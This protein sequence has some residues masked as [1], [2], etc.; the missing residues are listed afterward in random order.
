MK[1]FNNNDIK[2]STDAKC[3]E[4]GEQ[5]Y[6]QQKINAL[7]ITKRAIDDIKLTASIADE[8]G[9]YQQ[10]ISLA[11]TIDEAYEI[12]SGC[13]CHAGGNCKHIVA[14]LLAYKNHESSTKLAD[15]EKQWLKQV[16]TVEL[17]SA[18]PEK[19]KFIAYLLKKAPSLNTV[20]VHFRLTHLLQSA[21][22]ANGRVIQLHHFNNRLMLPEYATATDMDIAKAL[23]DISGDAW[24]GIPLKGEA[25]Y[26]ALQK[27][28]STEHVYWVE[29]AHMPLRA[30]E[31]RVAELK[32]QN[33]GRDMRRLS[34]QILPD[35][36]VIQTSPAWYLDSKT[37]DVGPMQGASFTPHQWQVL[38][39]LPDIPLSDVAKYGA[40]ISAVLPG[41]PLE[42]ATKEMR[43][44]VNIT[45]APAVNLF[46]SK[47]NMG[48][49]QFVYTMRVRF[50]YDKYEIQ[51]LPKDT[52]SRFS[53]TKKIVNVR[54]DLGAEQQVLD[55]LGAEGFIGTV[56]DTG[57]DIEFVSANSANVIESAATW[58]HF[59][60]D[61]VPV[62]EQ[63]GWHI[64]RDE[65]VELQFHSV[66]DWQIEVEDE[67]DWF[68]LRFDLDVNG[69]K[70]PLL[71]LISEILLSY[72]PDNMPETLVVPISG[73]EF[74]NVNSA[75]VKPVCQV[76]YELHDKQTLD[77]KGALR[78]NRC[79]ATRL[80]E[81]ETHLPDTVLWAGGVDLRAL[82]KRLN[83]FQ[84]IQPVSLPV[85]LNA[86]LRDYQC[87]GLN[88]MQFLREYKF[89][90]IL[91]DDMGLGKTLQTLTNLL[92]EKEAGRMD[93]PCLIVAPTSLM[94]NWRRESEKFTAALKVLIIHGSN[95][96]DKFQHIPAYDVI[97][98][99]Y[100]L[101]ARDK[102]QLLANKYYYLVL[103]E[104]QNIKN[105]N[106]HAAKIV[107]EIKAD[108]RLCLTG[109][110]MENHLGEL[111]AQLDFLMPGLLG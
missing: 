72:E 12:Q 107:R 97:L 104:A 93:K 33:A 30:G 73:D 7:K 81:L 71:P 62:L 55:R 69:R 63:A 13:N 58:Q 66:G 20:S 111:W 52:V 35:A 74:I 26:T 79:D 46:L 21:S 29:N 41:A 49:G 78:L 53:S 60:Q 65:G 75:Q 16:T 10:H 50:M 91:A 67:N 8:Q 15:A 14:V 3:F 24:E 48:H 18:I 86:E 108:Y 39:Q 64:E 1:I 95:R 57:G 94:S 99:T 68:D 70:V 110:P 77:A 31:R 5:Y 9:E 11:Y 102:E 45:Q 28:L 25:G 2:K 105:P 54:R 56:A 87:Q 4:E 40:Q 82:G 19:K 23:G 109:T 32:W 37:G 92:L 47:K 22:L 76:L 96:H 42:T 103:D 51:P 17:S 84:G 101:L 44:T 90:G 27:M 106:T 98:T 85:G 6:Q 100:P 88:W 61:V 43:E 89:G 83:D 59:L 38:A 34:L 36:Y 80:S